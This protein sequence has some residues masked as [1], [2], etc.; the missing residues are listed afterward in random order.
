MGQGQ[1]EMPGSWYFSVH[2]H[3]GR[4]T[5]LPL[6]LF[7]LL[8]NEIPTQRPLCTHRAVTAEG[9]RNCWVNPSP[10]GRRYQDVPGP[11]LFNLLCC[12]AGHRARKSSHCLSSRGGLASEHRQIKAETQSASSTN[13]ITESF[14]FW[15]LIICAIKDCV[16]F[17]VSR[18]YWH[19]FPSTLVWVCAWNI[20]Y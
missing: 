20:N 16:P 14:I 2:F 4:F 3:K 7:Q 9:A 18:S 8:C 12:Q 1:E 5:M 13:L 17:W 11:L 6:G 10:T 19:Q 15:S